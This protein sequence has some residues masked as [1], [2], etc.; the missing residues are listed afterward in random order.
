M[1]GNF[2]MSFSPSWHHDEL[3][4]AL[5]VIEYGDYVDSL[6]NGIVPS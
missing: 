2:T 1:F 5:C 3:L 6:K 4:L